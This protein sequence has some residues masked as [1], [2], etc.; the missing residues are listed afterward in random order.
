[1]DLTSDILQVLLQAAVSILV[2]TIPYTVP[3]L[4]RYSINTWGELK[5]T[6]PE[7]VGH[8]IEQAARIGVLAAEQYLKNEDIDLSE[9]KELALEVAE[10]WLHEQ[11]YNIDL[12]VIDDAI[13][14]FLGG[15]N[16][17]KKSE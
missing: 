4:I 17:W 6:M 2:V 9:R 12:T 14:A 15:I 1:V 13:E 3:K 10:R 8:M 5:A 11:G 7:Q 16:N